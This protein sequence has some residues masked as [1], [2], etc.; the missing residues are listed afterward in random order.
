MY[1]FGKEMMLEQENITVTGSEI[2]ALCET[3][4]IKNSN[5]ARYV[6]SVKE[7]ITVIGKGKS[8]KY[9]LTLHGRQKAKTLINELN[10]K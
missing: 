10:E 8:K 2:I 5:T 1:L 9:K 7:W 6:S 3:Q 4:G